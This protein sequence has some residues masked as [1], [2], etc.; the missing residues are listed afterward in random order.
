MSRIDIGFKR[1]KYVR[2]CYLLS[3]LFQDVDPEIIRVLANTFIAYIQCF[4]VFRFFRGAGIGIIESDRFI[5]SQ[6]EFVKNFR[7][8][9]AFVILV[10]QLF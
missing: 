6:R 8:V 2:S 3:H 10:S 1:I 4:F 9:R 7:V 5:I